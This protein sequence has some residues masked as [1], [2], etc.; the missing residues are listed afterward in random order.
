LWTDEGPGIG[1]RIEGAGL[2]VGRLYAHRENRR[3]KSEMVKVKLLAKVGRGGKVKIRFEEG[4]H[5]GLEEYIRTANLIVAWGESQGGPSRR[6]ALPA[7]RGELARF[8]T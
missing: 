6:G 4:P 3:G 2:E 7:D 5:P 1:S 8:E